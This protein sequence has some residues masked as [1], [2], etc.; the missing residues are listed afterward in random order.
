MIFDL[1]WIPDFSYFE[2]KI[3]SPLNIERALFFIKEKIASKEVFNSNEDLFWTLALLSQIDE[4]H[5]VDE[6]PIRNFIRKS[7]SSMRMF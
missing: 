5:L 2:Y 3:K 4:L 6:K 7:I 1:N